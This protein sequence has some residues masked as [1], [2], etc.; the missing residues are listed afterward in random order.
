MK[1]SI[2]RKRWHIIHR[3][4]IFNN[5]NF[6]TNLSL[7]IITNTPIYSA[8][9]MHSTSMGPFKCFY[10]DP[11][12]KIFLQ[13]SY[14]FLYWLKGTKNRNSVFKSKWWIREKNITKVALGLSSTS[15]SYNNIAQKSEYLEETMGKVDKVMVSYLE[16]QSKMKRN[17]FREIFVILNDNSVVFVVFLVAPLIEAK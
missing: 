11:R 6:K 3:I 5:R 13:P 15:F 8:L 17:R 10:V 14:I 1:N 9:R 2:F 16:S 12:R 4:D 7:V